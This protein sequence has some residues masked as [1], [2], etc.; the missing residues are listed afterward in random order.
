MSQILAPYL[1]RRELDVLR[2][3][4]EGQGTRQAARVLGISP[5]TFR[6]H[7]QNLLQKLGVH[8]RIRAV[9]EGVELGI[10]R[11]ER[12]ERRPG[13]EGERGHKQ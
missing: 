6:T 13:R 10:V 12:E 8:S 3:L 11:I 1:T 7:V 4:A 5:N 9:L 2:A